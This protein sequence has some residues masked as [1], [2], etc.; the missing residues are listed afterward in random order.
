M[1]ERIQKIL[2]QKGYGSRRAIEQHIREGLITVNGKI[3]VLGQ[4]IDCFDHV[5]LRGKRIHFTEDSERARLPRLLIYYKAEGEMCT[6]SDPQGR[7]TVF[8]RLPHL[9]ESRWVAVGRLD[10]NTSGLLLFTNN[11]QLAN[12]MMHP[13]L[14]LEREYA[15]RIQ[16]FVTSTQIDNLQKGVMLEDGKAAFTKIYTKGGK[17]VNHWYHVVVKE[18]RNRLVRRLWQSQGITVNRLIRIRYGTFHL[19]RDMELRKF[20][21]VSVEEVKFLMK[22]LKM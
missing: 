1:K 21:E 18:G 5:F 3:A 10:I 11:G 4:P 14:G 13:R 17:G 20:Y 6:R 19:K 16:G 15:V 9:K 2:A 8:Q 12:A 22:T 7:P